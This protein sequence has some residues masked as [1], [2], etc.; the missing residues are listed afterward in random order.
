MLS[1]VMF[2]LWAASAPGIFALLARRATT[3]GGRTAA[4]GGCLAALG[5]LGLAAFQFLSGGRRDAQG[6]L[7]LFFGPAYAWVAALAVACSLWLGAWLWRVL[8][9]GGEKEQR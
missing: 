6:A 7:I 4:W 9:L 5:V 8:G 1:R 3:K 2:V